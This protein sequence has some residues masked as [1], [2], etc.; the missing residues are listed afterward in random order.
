MSELAFA[1]NA[2]IEPHASPNTTYFIVI[3]GGGWVGVG[4]E[5]TR[6]AAGEAAVWPADILHA[7][8]TEH[9]EMRAFVVEFMWADDR[10]T[11]IGRARAVGPGDRPVA[12]G[13]GQL[14]PRIGP[15]PDRPDRGRTRLTGAD[16]RAVGRPGRTARR[17]D[18]SAAQ[19]PSSSIRSRNRTKSWTWSV[20]GRPPSSWA[21]SRIARR[22][23]PS[24]PRSA[25]SASAAAAT[26][27]SSRKV[28]SVA[29]N[30]GARSL[31]P[32][33][34]PERGLDGWPSGSVQRRRTVPRSGRGASLAEPDGVEG[35]DRVAG[36]DG[37]GVD[38]SVAEVA[39]GDRPG[40]RSR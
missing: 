18:A 13:A 6:I 22:S 30:R 1:R 9:S 26:I 14:A 19:P 12:R 20:A 31:G 3:E 10:D 2:R 33:L 38:T 35:G 7:A 40:S 24:E 4:D 8:W 32:D 16:G 34:A 28:G 39:V 5:R 29:A 25:R 11:V 36:P 23:G 27:A 37:A 15:P 17:P 21:T